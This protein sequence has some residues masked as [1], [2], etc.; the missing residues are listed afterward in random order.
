[1]KDKLLKLLKFCNLTDKDNNLSISN[2]A[3]IVV[4]IKIAL[5][6]TLDWATAATLLMAL[7]NYGHKRETTIKAIKEAKKDDALSDLTSSLKNVA[8]KVEK[9]ENTIVTVAKQAEETKKQLSQLNLGNAFSPN[10]R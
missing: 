9:Y 5:A 3:V 4:I 8:A 10:K 2:I 7:L 6:A 1:M